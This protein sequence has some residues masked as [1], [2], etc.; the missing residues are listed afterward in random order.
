MKRKVK[1]LYWKEAVTGLSIGALI[2]A[3]IWILKIVLLAAGW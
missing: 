2:C 3:L 1:I